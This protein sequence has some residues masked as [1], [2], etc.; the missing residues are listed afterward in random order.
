MAPIEISDGSIQIKLQSLANSI[1]SGALILLLLA[2][3]SIPNRAAG[4]INCEIANS[5][6]ITPTTGK[7][8]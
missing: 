5:G 4:S 6:A 3:I 2:F 8:M 7:L 1:N